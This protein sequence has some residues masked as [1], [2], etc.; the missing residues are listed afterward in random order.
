MTMG[1]RTFSIASWVSHVGNQY[2]TIRQAV[3]HTEVSLV[4]L[5]EDFHG[6]NHLEKGDTRVL[7]PPTAQLS[8]AHTPRQSLWPSETSDN[9][10][11]LQELSAQDLALARPHSSLGTSSEASELP[12]TQTTGTQHRLTRNSLHGCG[13]TPLI[14]LSREATG[15]EKGS[16]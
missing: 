7:Q 5:P 12:S 9:L 13:V 16:R 2:V 1:K 14:R 6:L 8:S 11:R 3:N 4:A 15:T 10:W